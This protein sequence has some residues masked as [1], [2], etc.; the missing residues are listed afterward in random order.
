MVDEVLAHGG[1]LDDALGLFLDSG[2]RL[3]NE[4]ITRLVIEN[5]VRVAPADDLL[6]IATIMAR[7]MIRRLHVLDGDRFVGSISRADLLWGLLSKD[8]GRA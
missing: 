1:S 5:P 8:R 4:P 7:K 6:K 2:E 3:A